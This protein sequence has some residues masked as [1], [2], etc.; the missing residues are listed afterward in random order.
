MTP[1]VAPY[2]SLS[3]DIS[4]AVRQVRLDDNPLHVSFISAQEHVV[5][6]NQVEKAAWSNARLELIVDLPD[7]EL[8]RGRADWLDV[9]CH[10]VVAERRT[11]VRRAVQLTRG[12]D[13]RWSGSVELH[14]DD[15]VSRAELDAVV[16]ARVGGVA[17]RVIGMSTEPWTV[18]FVSRTPTRQRSIATKWADFAAPENGY[19]GAY[20]D[21]PWVVDTA[22]IDPVVYLNSGFEGFKTLL[23]GSTGTRPQ[24]EAVT[25]QIAAESWIALFNT[26]AVRL[27]TDDAEGDWP[28]GWHEAVLR[29]LLPDVYPETTPTDALEEV[30]R[31]IGESGGDL[32]TRVLNVALVQA[33]M[34]RALTALIRDRNSASEEAKKNR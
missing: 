10:V 20:R 4:L 2:P 7:A 6:L 19:L 18:D 12:V 22:G 5:A 34:P 1:S 33:R 11:C 31:Q 3:G 9:G 30:R 28:G 32:Q 8:E 17:G 27:V 16:T 15:H 23:S 24:R 21:V 13:G 14:R 25:A 26:A 29:R